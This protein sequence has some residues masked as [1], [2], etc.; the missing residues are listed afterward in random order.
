MDTTW[1]YVTDSSWVN[2]DYRKFSY[3][4][5][6]YYRYLE[7]PFVV[8]IRLIQQKNL[9]FYALGGIIPAFRIGGKALLIQHDEDN[10][11]EWIQKSEIT[12][13]LI[14]WQAGVGAILPLGSR[15]ELFAECSF[16][17]QLGSQLRDFPV[18]K[19]F[20]AVNIK[21]GIFVRL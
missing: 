18:R 12:A 6:N 1:F 16:R 10:S 17:N 5:P 4:H 19:N 14:S 21:T 3:N 7:L 11:V 13:F 8:R 20:S 15:W 2:I 9:E